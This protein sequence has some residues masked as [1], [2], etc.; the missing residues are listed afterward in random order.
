LAKLL[1]RAGVRDGAVEVMFEGADRGLAKEKPTPPDE[2]HYA[3]SVP[4][5]K[6][7]DALL[8]Y[9]MNGQ[10]LSL[11]HGFPLRAIVGGWYG[12][13]SVKWVQRIVVLAEPFRGYFRTV[14]YAY[15]TELEGNPV[16]VPIEEMSCKA[17]I[18]RPAKGEIVPRDS[19]YTVAGAA[20]TGDSDV[21]RV[22]VS[23]DG[24]KTF[25]DATLLGE[26]I[27]HAWT[28]WTF[29][30]HTPA[31]PGPVTLYARATDSAGRVQAFERNPMH[32]TY[33]IDH[34]LPCEREV[35]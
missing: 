13:A 33:V 6:I 25:A 32:G 16:R 10:T 24:G 18:A 27:R 11:A 8:A 20:W 28:L 14:D 34:M 1:E 22:E 30:W 35:E 7:G 23:T 5:R 15:W 26:A 3:H 21:V 12:M 31:Q 17:Q 19:E 9:R 4:M 2:T 29:D